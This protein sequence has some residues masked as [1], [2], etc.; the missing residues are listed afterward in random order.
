M[1]LSEK[2]L[3]VASWLEDSE[4]DLIVNAE[5]D[6]H[7]LTTVASALVKAAVALKEAATEVEK[8]EPTTLTP[9]KLDE[10]AAVAQEFDASGDEYLM[11]QASVIDELLLTIAAPRGAAIQFRETQDDR[12]EQLKKKYNGPKTELDEINK[13]SDSVKAIEKA[14]IYKQYRPLEAPLSSRYCPDHAGGLVVRVGEHTWQ[15]VL[16]K[17]IYNYDTG[18]KTMQGNEVPGG[19]VENQIQDRPQ[20]EHMLFDTRDSRLGLNDGK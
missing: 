13:V 1:K 20:E 3:L 9:E 10:L 4:N 11:K 19:G 5:G 2:I 6:E 17:K 18:F 15:C 12:I 14:P 8:T 16:D 7:S